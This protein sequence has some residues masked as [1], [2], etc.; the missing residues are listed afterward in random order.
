MSKVTP[1]IEEII[2]NL[3]KKGMSPY[4]ISD[5]LG[6]RVTHTAIRNR[7]IDAG[8]EMRSR[9]D[10]KKKHPNVPEVE[11]LKKEYLDEGQSCYALGKK[12]DV[13]PAVIWYRLN[14]AGVPMKE[15]SQ[16]RRSNQDQ[17]A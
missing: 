4:E 10:A 6:G 3:Y 14:K 13:S 9:S 5:A 17:T 11:V 16:Q 1:E 7:L 15:I 2:V 8:V 12:Y